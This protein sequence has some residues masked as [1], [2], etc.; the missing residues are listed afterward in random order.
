MTSSPEIFVAPFHFEITPPL[1]H[2]LLAGLVMPAQHHDDALEA[3]GY[4]LLGAG[5]PLV[6]CVL[7]WAALMNA[8]QLA[9][10]TVLAEA[11]GTTPD[12]VAVHCV[13]QHNT[14]FVCFGA[15]AAAA[16][17]PELPEMFS[18]P[19]FAE[20]LNR[21]CTAVRDALPKARR[22][23]HVAHGAAVVEHVASNRR[24][25]RDER[26]MIIEMR[27]SACTNP[28]LIAL[29]EG[30]ID[31][32]LQT[33][34]LYGEGG[35]KLISSHYYAT[36][37]MSFYRDGRVTSD[38][39][40]LARKRRQADEPGCTHL[41]FT[42][43]AGNIAAGKYNDGSPAARA[44][45]TERMY[46]GLLASEAH[47]APQPLSSVDWRVEAILPPPQPQ[48]SKSELEA[49]LANPDRPLADRLLSAFQLSWRQRFT[50]G[51]PLL[52]SRLRLNDISV[53]H[54]PGEMFIEYQ[55]RA[56]ALR[57]NHPVAVAAYGDDGLW[58]VPTKDEYP[59]GGY[60]VSVAFSRDE[61][62]ELMMASIQ[63]LL[64]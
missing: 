35:Q 28:A 40:G 8:A 30:T 51:Q 3:I 29:P 52:L 25:Y 17:Y 22:V 26:G 5:T 64:A 31:P 14:P 36:H 58:Y 13:H 50:G 56:R 19:F 60:E 62:D 61:V 43:C 59:A 32:Q 46:Q 38:F 27:A 2:A 4:I 33:I 63:R 11:A 57:P 16:A 42:G 20:C 12:R 55:L 23:T 24:V 37:P 1:G 49:T 53:L 21:A 6:V 54:L 9:W 44:A 7:D 45:L 41:Y 47:L 10:R 34:A 18:L 39:C 48:P 15:R